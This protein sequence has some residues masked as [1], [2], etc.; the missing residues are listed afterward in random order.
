VGV[1]KRFSLREKY[2]V[3]KMIKSKAIL[4]GKSGNVRKSEFDV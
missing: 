4:E 3:Q 1:F 2:Y